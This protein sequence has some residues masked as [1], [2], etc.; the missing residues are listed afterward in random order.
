MLQEGYLDIYVWENNWKET[1]D[2]FYDNPEI[3]EKFGLV[4]C[5]DGEVIG[6]VTWDPRNRSCRAGIRNSFL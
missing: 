1:D 5:L 6:F 2:F 3:A 4:T